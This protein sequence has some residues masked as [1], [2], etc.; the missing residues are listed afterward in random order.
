VPKKTKDH[1]SWLIE[2]LTDPAR[3]AAYLNAAREDSQ[4]MLFE[5]LRD[6]A[7]ARQMS[8]VAREAKITRE[9][10]Y[11]VT[12]VVGNPNYDTFDSVLDALGLD[13][14]IVPKQVSVVSAKSA[15]SGRTLGTEYAYAASPNK[16]QN[17]LAS[18]IGIGT[19][20]Q[21]GQ[22]LCDTSFVEVRGTVQQFIGGTWSGSMIPAATG[23]LAPN[24]PHL[25]SGEVVKLAFMQMA[26]E[27]QNLAPLLP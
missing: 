16:G 22:G 9:S 24:G 10:L 11:K 27:S 20:P 15:T 3:A 17:S 25:N 14:I 18:G 21:P 1:Q 6:V 2:K 23:G 13:F 12:S 4:E 7:Q 19:L 26:A 5:A 8:K